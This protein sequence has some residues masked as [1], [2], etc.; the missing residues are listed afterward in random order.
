ML[1]RSSSIT[2]RLCSSS[3]PSIPRL[4]RFAHRDVVIRARHEALPRKT[5]SDII[6][7]NGTRANKMLAHS[8]QVRRTAGERTRSSPWTRSAPRLQSDGNR[9]ARRSHDRRAS[10][11][12]ACFTYPARRRTAGTFVPALGT[13][14]TLFPLGFIGFF[15]RRLLPGRRGERIGRRSY[16]LGIECVERQQNQLN[17]FPSEPV[18]LVGLFGLQPT[19]VQQI[20]ET[21]DTLCQGLP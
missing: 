1:T 12:A 17:G 7:M 11:V 5:G 14:F 15:V 9:P 8:G 4:P 19:V 21:I 10:P 16:R 20:N 3:W 18:Q 2:R 13:G 6:I